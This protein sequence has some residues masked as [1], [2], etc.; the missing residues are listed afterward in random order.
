MIIVWMWGFKMREFE[1]L[2]N[3]ELKKNTRS[4]KLR[5]SYRATLMPDEYKTDKRY[6]SL[7]AN[8]Y[9]QKK[10]L[11]ECRL[12]GI[13]SVGTVIGGHIADISSLLK[14]AS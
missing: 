9:K 12:V 3:K 11:A 8:L 10:R 1:S 2:S 6:V 13:K 7:V 4:T 5:E 14:E